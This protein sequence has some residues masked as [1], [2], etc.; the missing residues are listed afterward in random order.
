MR[1]RRGEKEEEEEKK[2]KKKRSLPK[3]WKPTLMCKNLYGYLSIEYGNLPR[4]VW[5]FV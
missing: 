1:E 4:F 2:K 3:V 5:N